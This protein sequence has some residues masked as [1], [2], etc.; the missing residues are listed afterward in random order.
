MRLPHGN[1]DLAA[2]SQYR[3]FRSARLAV[4]L[5]LEALLAQALAAF[6]PWLVPLPIAKAAFEWSPVR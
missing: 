1:V 2:V 6:R 5:A 3:P 4:E